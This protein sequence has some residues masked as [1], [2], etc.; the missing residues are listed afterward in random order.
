MAFMISASPPSLVI[1]YLYLIV[2]F[3]FSYNAPPLPMHRNSIWC[4]KPNSLPL[5]G[6]SLTSGTFSAKHLCDEASAFHR[7]NI[8]FRRTY[9]KGW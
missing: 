2:C 3:L 8:G 9:V 7:K 1:V 4:V 6:S 5:A